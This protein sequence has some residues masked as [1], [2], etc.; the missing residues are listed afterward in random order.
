[1][2]CCAEK[3]FC[4]CSGRNH[5]E[6]VSD[7]ECEPLYAGT[8]TLSLQKWSHPDLPNTGSERTIML[9]HVMMMQ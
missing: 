2:P 1:M 8:G 4:R 5:V 7:A 3:H 9:E 6:V